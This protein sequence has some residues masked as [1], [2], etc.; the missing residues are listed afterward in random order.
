MALFLEILDGE[1]QGQR[2]HLVPGLRI[3]RTVGEVLIKDAKASSLHAQIEKD[4]KGQLI[5]VDRKSSNGLRVN[6]QRVQKVTMLPGVKFYI[7]KTGLKVVQLF[8]EDEANDS[9]KAR[10]W[11]GV[12]IEGVPRI[13]AQNRTS[14]AGVRPFDQAIQLEFLEGLQAGTTL[15]LGYGPRKFGG[16]V[17]DI[18]IQD[19]CSPDIAFEII[20]EGSVV[21]FLTQF[22]HIV[23][24]NER[25]LS[26]EL[27]T[28]GD[29]IRIGTSLI[30][31]QFIT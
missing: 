27:L 19:P 1:D 20:P 22:P 6:G 9:F 8:G 5:L 2:F 18:E 12:L 23:L 13:L 15:V 29:R 31:V 11:R 16:D 7:G 17:L 21:R 26:S 14:L 4:G 24:L 25:S 30:E 10:G 28:A 3:G